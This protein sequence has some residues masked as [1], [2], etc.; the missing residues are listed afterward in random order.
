M[1]SVVVQSLPEEQMKFV[2]NAA[3]DVLPHNN[4]LHRWKTRQ[5]PSCPLCNSNQSLLHV[6]N[7]S[8]VAISLK[9]YNVHHDKIVHEIS[10]VVRAHLAPS[11]SMAV[12]IGEGYAFPMHIVPTDLRPDLVW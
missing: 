5:D 12:D 11:A 7:N 4:N 8:S 2:L 6:L 10:T 1:W 9:R 3:L